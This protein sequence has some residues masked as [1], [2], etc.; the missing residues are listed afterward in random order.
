MLTL[1]RNIGLVGA[2]EVIR[3]SGI[4]Y[5]IIRSAW[6]TD[7]VDVPHERGPHRD[8]DRWPWT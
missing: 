3:G 8:P 7:G 5:W 4:P 1:T 6:L 2:E